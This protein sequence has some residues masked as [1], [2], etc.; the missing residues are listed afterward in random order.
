MMAWVRRFS[1]RLR[2]IFGGGRRDA[3]RER[4]IA[5][6]LA[7]MADDL[8]TKGMTPEEALRQAH[9]RLGNTTLIREEVRQMDGVPALENVGRDVAYA[10]RQLRK[11]K[12]FAIAA[13]VTL[14]LGIG[15]AAAMY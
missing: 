3:D 8:A 5:A 7:L 13:I 9:I 1:A 10:L 6:H 4:E 11:S 14:A 12:G 15:A 2:G